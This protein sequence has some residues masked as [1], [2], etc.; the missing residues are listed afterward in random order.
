MRGGIF[1][2][3]DD[4]VF[5]SRIAH[6]KHISA[7]YF[8]AVWEGHARQPVGFIERIFSNALRAIPYH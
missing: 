7:D 6:I 8:H 2:T 4:Y 5:V 1:I 3:S